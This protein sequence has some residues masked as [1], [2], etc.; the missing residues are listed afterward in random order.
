MYGAIEAGGTKFVVTVGTGPGDMLS[1]ASIATSND[2]P[3]ET[4][5]EVVEYLKRQETLHGPLRAIGIGSFGPIDFSSGRITTTPKIAWRNFPLRQQIVSAFGVPVGFDTDVNAAALGEGAWGAAQGLSDFVYLT[6]GTGIGGGAVVNGRLVHGVLHT[7]M[8]HMLLPLHPREKPDFAGSCPS[9]RNCLESLASGPS[10]EKRWGRNA[11]LLGPDEEAWDLEAWYLA[12]GMVNLVCVL[13]PKRII[14]GGGVMR[15]THL[16]ARI[17]RGAAELLNGYIQAPE[18][19]DHIDDYIVPP[20]LE[21][22]GIAG[23]LA[24]ARE[25]AGD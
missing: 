1:P 9:H 13:S 17:R 15:K 6:V 11:A 25:A 16:F 3:A 14:L 18:I 12:H 20:A 22:P 23:A 4:I 8:G 2:K 5:L 21:W 10:I 24:L 19:L 7:E